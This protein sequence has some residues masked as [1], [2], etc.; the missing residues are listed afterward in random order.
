MSLQ[1]GKKLNVIRQYWFLKSKLILLV[2]DQQLQ[3][4]PSASQI[5][6]LHF[7][8]ELKSEWPGK[9]VCKTN[10]FILC[11]CK[12]AKICQHALMSQERPLFKCVPN[13]KAR[14]FSIPVHQI[15]YQFRGRNSCRS[16]HHR[17]L[18][19]GVGLM[20]SVLPFGRPDKEGEQ[21]QQHSR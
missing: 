9:F 11:V 8:Q 21:T 12:E 18:S 6:K 20:Q 17:V 5:T 16:N 19:L 7:L 15:R 3:I 10:F 2:V 1:L 4:R 13:H 14:K